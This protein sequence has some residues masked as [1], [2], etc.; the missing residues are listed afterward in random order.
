MSVPDMKL[1]R[2]EISCPTGYVSEETYLSEEEYE[3][4]Y[5]LTEALTSKMKS[6]EDPLI[7]IYVVE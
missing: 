7:T 2:I 4:I 1:Y 3:K 6:A 5:E